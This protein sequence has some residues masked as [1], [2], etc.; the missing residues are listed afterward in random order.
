LKT[1]W[2][3]LPAILFSL[4]VSTL[5]AHADECDRIA[6]ALSEQQGA[7]VQK[8]SGEMIAFD[9]VDGAKMTLTC[10]EGAYDD[11]YDLNVSQPRTYP[12]P[13]RLSSI[14]AAGAIVSGMPAERI[15]D[16]LGACVAGATRAE[17][18]GYEMKEGAVT[19]WCTLDLTAEYSNFSIKKFTK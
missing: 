1:S 12:T 5:S 18:H 16:M 14:A 8:R 10:A 4:S 6:A 7:T 3:T 15:N 9:D 11:A 17:H 19:I 2:W 13:T